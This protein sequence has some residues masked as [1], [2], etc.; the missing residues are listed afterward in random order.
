MNSSLPNLQTCVISSKQLNIVGANLTLAFDKPLTVG[1]YSMIVMNYRSASSGQFKLQPVIGLDSSKCN[2]ASQSY[3]SSSL[4]MLITVADGSCSGNVGFVTGVTTSPATIA[5]WRS[6][7][8]TIG[9]SE[10]FA[11]GA[12]LFTLT[13]VI[14]MIRRQN[15]MDKRANESLKKDEIENLKHISQAR[16]GSGIE[17]T[18]G[19]K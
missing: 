14:I 8:A 5:G 18:S 7:A 13:I 17:W 2:T 3:S 15:G 10:G 12:I 11:C 1:T 9:I 19:K 6:Q 16:A 4:S